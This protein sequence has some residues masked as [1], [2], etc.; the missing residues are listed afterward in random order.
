MF[1]SISALNVVHNFKKQLFSYE[2]KNSKKLKSIL[3]LYISDGCKI[4]INDNN[5]ILKEKYFQNYASI[6]ALFYP[7]INR[8][9]KFR[10]IEEKKIGEDNFFVSGYFLSPLEKKVNVEFLVKNRK[11]SKI[12]C[13]NLELNHSQKLALSLIFNLLGS[14][15][16]SSKK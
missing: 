8:K 10:V 7:K 4:N 5:L 13:K 12:Q 3:D 11:I 14:K 6:G 2:G 9:V 1:G 16:H 15:I